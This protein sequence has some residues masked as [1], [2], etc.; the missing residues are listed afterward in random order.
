MSTRQYLSRSVPWQQ[1]QS[2]TR[3]LGRASRSRSPCEGTRRH[4]GLEGVGRETSGRHC[5]HGR[6]VGQNQEGLASGIDDT[7]NEMG[8]FTVV[9]AESHEAAAKLFEKHPHFA[10]FPGDSVE[11]MPVLPIPG[12]ALSGRRTRNI[13]EIMPNTVRLHRVL[14][15]K[16]EKVYRAFIEPDAMAKWLPPNGFTCTVH[17]MDPTVGGTYRMSFRNFTTGM[18]TRSEA[19]MSSSYPASACATTISSRTRTCRV[20]FELQ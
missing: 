5:Q 9:R 18:A 15:T 20:R 16:P 7:S 4:G 13:Q 3:G 14:A 6:T 17:H 19:G 10:I 8:A 12:G 1:N 11:I 2:A